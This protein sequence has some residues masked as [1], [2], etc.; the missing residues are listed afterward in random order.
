MGAEIEARYRGRGSFYPARVVE[1]NYD[2]TLDIVYD[3]GE[4]F[5]GLEQQ[6]ARPRMLQPREEEYRLHGTFLI[7]HGSSCLNAS[8]LYYFNVV[9]PPK[10]PA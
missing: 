8:R 2:G 1:V 5:S 3:D 7:H 10:R 6:D 9:R 4:R